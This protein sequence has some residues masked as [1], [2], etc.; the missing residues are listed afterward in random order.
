MGEEASSSGAP[1]N[2]LAKE[3]VAV[4]VADL[5]KRVGQLEL[6]SLFSGE[7][8]ERDAV[9]EVHAGAGGTDAQDWAEMMLR[10]YPRWA[11]RRGFEVE[12]DENTRARRRGCCRPRSS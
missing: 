5:A 8:D 1:D 9:A 4:S 2:G 7:H 11:E 12:V 6:Q 10:M 3:L